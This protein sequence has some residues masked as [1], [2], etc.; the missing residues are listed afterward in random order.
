MVLAGFGLV[1]FLTTVV[2][3]IVTFGNV[4]NYEAR[5]RLEDICAFGGMA[6]VIAGSLVV[7]IGAQTSAEAEASPGWKPGHEETW[8]GLSGAAGDD[9]FSEVMTVRKTE[10][11]LDTADPQVRIRCRN[12]QALNDGFAKFCNQCGTALF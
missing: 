6:L 11:W 4:K 9:A 5:A 10:E 7:S 12:C 8:S 2:T 3:S 1:L